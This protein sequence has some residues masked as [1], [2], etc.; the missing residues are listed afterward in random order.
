M[1]YRI[2]KKILLGKHWYKK[3]QALRPM[4]FDETTGY[5]VQPSWHDIPD[6]QFQKARR[7]Y[8]GY[9]RK[10]SKSKAMEE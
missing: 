9:W 2:A 6:A 10:V 3:W 5:W 7:R 1:K 4:Y 8:F